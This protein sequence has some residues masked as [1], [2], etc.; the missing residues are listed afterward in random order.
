MLPTIQPGTAAETSAAQP[1]SYLRLSARAAT[2]VV[3]MRF[4][5]FTCL[6]P[7]LLLL[8]SSTV[9]QAFHQ[10]RPNNYS[11]TTADNAATKLN[12][13]LAKG[14]L[15]LDSEAKTSRGRLRALLEAL[16]VP[17]SSQTLVFSKT[18][19]QRHRVSP[20][21]PRALYFNED[22][23]VGWIPGAAS[24]EVIV[25]DP[26][27][28]LA[29]YS[30]P[31]DANQPAR[32]TRDDGCL[33]CH[34]TSRTQDEPGLVLRS[35]FPDLAGDPIPSAGETDMNFRSPIEERWGGWLV[36]GQFEGAHRGNNTATRNSEGKWVVTP[37]PARDL[38][39]FA[40]DFGADRYLR[41]TSDIGA[42][43]ALEQQATVH[44]L[45]VRATHQ[46]R[47]LLDK[48]RVLNDL[49]GE[50][51]SNEHGMR[52]S[53]QR[54]ADT[55]A[56]EI[57]ATLL[58]DGEAPLAQHRAASNAEFARDFAAMWPKDSDGVQ[59]G[60]LDVSKRTF[61]LP[62]SPMIHSKAFQR[63]PTELRSRVF[64]R[65]QVAIERGVPPGNVQLDR[66]TRA[67]LAKHLRDTM[68]DWPPPRV[69]RNQ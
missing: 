27:L 51:Q 63:L 40:K 56:K 68:T 20:Q 21:N 29:F 15:Q 58:L 35:V 14:E 3:P 23:Y 11:R 25:G 18:S 13:R 10:R 52:A 22:V 26:E 1:H 55:L 7:A 37:K 24:I 4:A 17:A 16:E 59:L 62:M 67:I 12:K 19:L 45:L 31:Q 64:A 41:P 34:A 2:I 53:T 38:H 8:A 54:I 43:L 39:A 42:L 66:A 60:E 28:G 46:M 44:N 50:T 61:V 6:T 48:D 36:T 30:M 49:L 65:L 69:R 32:L 33:S 9:A 57:A 5:L 47:Y